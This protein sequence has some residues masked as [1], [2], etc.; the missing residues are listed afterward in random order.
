MDAGRQDPWRQD[1][2][3]RARGVP[4]TLLEA[5]SLSTALCGVPALVAVAPDAGVGAW[6][7][8][9]LGPA[10]QS[11]SLSTHRDRIIALAR[12][13]C[14]STGAPPRPVRSDGDPKAYGGVVE[15]AG[16]AALPWALD[17]RHGA[18]VLGTQAG[19]ASTRQAL[20]AARIA[21][22]RLLHTACETRALEALGD[23]MLCADARGI[24][25]VATERAAA[26]LGLPRGRLEGRSLDDT[27]GEAC[28]VT[29]AFDRLEMAE[30]I[31]F[32]A[33]SCA[34]EAVAV[35]ASRRLAP[36]G[37]PAGIVVWI[38][39]GSAVAPIARQRDRQVA[40]IRHSI[41]APLTVLRGVTSMLREEPQMPVSDRLTFLASVERE[42]GRVIAMV[43][44]LLTCA[45]LEAGLA[46]ERRAPVELGAWA[47]QLAA[48]FGPW[49][50]EHGHEIDVVDP[51]PP[52][53]ALADRAL[54][55]S[56]GRAVLGHIFKAAPPSTRVSISLRAGADGPI[57]LRW[58]DDAPPL[59]D[60]ESGT[61]FT[62]F[63]RSTAA[64]K[65]APG[66]GVGLPIAKLVA[67]AH[68]WGM[69][70][71]R[72]AQGRNLIWARLPAHEPCSAPTRS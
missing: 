41:R 62:G 19:R 52:R 46:L 54:L 43:E 66:G 42:T 11:H 39:P 33:V 6:T 48:A 2:P 17:G 35:S 68:G 63:R 71:D 3:T 69:G 14:E 40:A 55:D 67:D 31:A 60:D 20:A 23:G 37:A 53:T 64:G 1:G 57:E 50:A 51:G 21:L 9:S 58:V 13:A 32:Q 34:D 36:D 30:Q 27:L 25:Q 12:E 29:V 10:G 45:R 65:Y 7:V 24:I 26:L 28:G 8:H 38:A 18:V 16:W 56:L 72:D 44:D 49:C 59:G 47:R 70:Y 22:A 5:L 61:L 4:P 15:R